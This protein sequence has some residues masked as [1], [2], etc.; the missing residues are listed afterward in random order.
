M[1]KQL[2]T[3]TKRLKGISSTNKAIDY[4]KELLSAY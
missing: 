2:D 3:V 4:N 1:N